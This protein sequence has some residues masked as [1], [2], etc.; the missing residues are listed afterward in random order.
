M[1]RLLCSVA[2]SIIGLNNLIVYCGGYSQWIM[3]W[4]L[5]RQPNIQ[6]GTYESYWFLIL[7][8]NR[9]GVT[10]VAKWVTSPPFEATMTPSGHYLANSSCANADVKYSLQMTLA[11]WDV[12]WLKRSLACTRL[13]VSMSYALWLYRP[14]CSLA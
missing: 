8:R 7:F 12:S 1:Q 13:L 9:I 10:R 11:Q 5:R 4:H 6:G 14:T 2:S 3:G